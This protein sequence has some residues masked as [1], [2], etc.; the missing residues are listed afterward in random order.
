MIDITSIITH[1]A[2]MCVID[3]SW[4]SSLF[5]IGELEYNSNEETRAWSVYEKIQ[6]LDYNRRVHQHKQGSERGNIIG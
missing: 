5:N 2:R 1:I 3:L 6:C 4:R